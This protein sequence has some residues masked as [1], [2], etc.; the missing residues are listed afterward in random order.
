MYICPLGLLKNILVRFD[1]LNT[2]YIYGH[3]ISIPSSIIHWMTNT[4]V[5]WLACKKKFVSFHFNSTISNWN[6]KKKI[7]DCRNELLP[8]SLDGH[9]ILALFVCVCCWSNRQRKKNDLTSIYVMSFIVWT[10]TKSSTPLKKKHTI[11]KDEAILV[12]TCWFSFDSNTLL[13]IEINKKNTFKH[14]QTQ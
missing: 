12:V 10:L 2:A 4:N 14:S 1:L 3:G 5:D 6:G 9:Y 7:V 8:W 13:Q 11:F